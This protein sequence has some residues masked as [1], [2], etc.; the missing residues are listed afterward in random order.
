MKK[1]NPCLLFFAGTIFG[2]VLMALPW[3]NL[4][5]PKPHVH[6]WKDTMVSNGKVTH[7]GWLVRGGSEDEAVIIKI[8]QCETCF[9]ERGAICHLD[10]SFEIID[11]DFIKRGVHN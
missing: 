3:S 10:G 5:P 1:I 7:T 2:L 8:Q 6:F 11:A 9:A 4:S